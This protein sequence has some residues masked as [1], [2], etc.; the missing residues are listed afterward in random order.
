MAKPDV[1]QH[2][3]RD[4]VTPATIN[5]KIASNDDGT[6][7]YVTPSVLAAILT[8]PQ[9]TL[10]LQSPS[11]AVFLLSVDDDGKIATSKEGDASVN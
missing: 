5:N 1:M 3:S 2:M 11:G 7:R 9:A 8:Q 10:K 6:E 4:G